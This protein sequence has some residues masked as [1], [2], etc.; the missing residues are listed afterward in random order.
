MARQRPPAPWVAALAGPHDTP[1]QALVLEE[2]RAAILSGRVRPG[3]PIPVDEVAARFSLS[4]IPVREALKTLVAEGLVTHQVRGAYVVA[5]L[6]REELA[7]LYVVRASLE[8]AAI[9]AAVSRAT[10]ADVGTAAAALRELEAATARGG[11]ADH[12]RWSRRFHMALLAPC[13]MHRLL[14]MLEGAW[15]VTEPGRPMSHASPQATAAL[16]ADHVGMLDAFAARDA[17]ALV[18]LTDVHY[19]RL[20]GIVADLPADP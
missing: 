2:L 8:H 13:Q 3:A 11:S 18:E 9:T 5:R 14:Q 10:P 4:S 6:T 7:E 19:R 12:H 1:S 20:Q 16:A 15:N 17:A